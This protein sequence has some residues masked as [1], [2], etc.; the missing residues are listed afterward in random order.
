MDWGVVGDFPPLLSSVHL[1]PHVG[2]FLLATAHHHPRVHK[3]PL[4]AGRSYGQI[5]S[6]FTPL[7][8]PPECHR[9]LPDL[10][11]SLTDTGWRRKDVGAG[12]NI[13]SNLE[14]L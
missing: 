5:Q 8:I 10:L 2:H 11:T 4:V 6:P 7:G 13:G 9:S 3:P 12:W 14:L 1:G